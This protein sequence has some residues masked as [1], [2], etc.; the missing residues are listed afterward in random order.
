MLRALS[1][2]AH[3]Y[4]Y[5]AQN[6]RGVR[7]VLKELAF[8]LAPD[9]AAIAAFERETDLL[10]QLSHPR[11]P[12][13]CASFREGQGAQTR[14][15]LAQELVEGSS[16]ESE[17]ARHRYSEAEVIDVLE[18]MLRVLVYLHG[19]S[20]PILHRDLKPANIIR[21]RDGALFLVD[22]GAAR[23]GGRTL[24]SATLVGTFGYMPPE[25]LAGQVDQTSDLFALGM[26]ALHLLAHRPP[27]ELFADDPD[28]FPKSI[29]ASPGL[30]RFLKRLTARRRSKRIPTARRA[31]AE[32]AK[33]V[34]GKAEAPRWLVPAVAA[35]GALLALGGL[36]V[37]GSRIWANPSQPVPQRIALAPRA[38]PSPPHRAEGATPRA[39]SK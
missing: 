35:L 6:A 1:R 3:A 31:L 22:F 12:R 14:F 34:E 33:V 9:A 4:T 15:Y 17:L 19:L 18:Q 36:A 21:R 7:F 28:S 20:P 25:Q 29:N 26:T 10:R 30:R 13:F 11:I 8:A 27:W 37:A 32:M 2:K 38:A 23:E 16:L 24:S 5:L 39:G